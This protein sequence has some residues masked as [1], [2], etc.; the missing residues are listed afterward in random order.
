MPLTPRQW[1]P[2]YQ[3]QW[4]HWLHYAQRASAMLRVA[5]ALHQEKSGS[6]EDWGTLH[7]GRGELSKLVLLFC[8]RPSLAQTYLAGLIND[9]LALANVQPRLSWGGPESTK[10]RFNLAGWGTF[11]ILGVQLMAAVTRSQHVYICDGCGF[12]YIRERKPQAG[13]R[14]YCPACGE[15]EANRQR[16]R[17]W[18]S[19]QQ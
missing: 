13:R 2:V 3:E 1:N 16:Q 15:R 6:R 9:W 11:G 17:K 18:R 7:V 12:P 10:P 8:Q 19:Q 4:S 14:N 5:A